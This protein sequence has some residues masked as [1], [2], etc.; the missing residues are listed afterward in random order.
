VLP[1]PFLEHPD[2]YRGQTDVAIEL[3]TA[4][5]TSAQQRQ[6]L[7]RWVEFLSSPRPIHRLELASRVPQ[8][9]VDAVGEQRSLHELFIKFG[10]FSDLAPLGTLTRL[11]VL[12]FGGAG[13]VSDVSPLV[14]LPALRELRLDNPHPEIDIAPLSELVRLRRLS[15]GNGYP[16]ISRSL[17]LPGV[18]WLAPLIDLEQLALPG[19]RLIDPDLTPLLGLP[20]LRELRLPLRRAY[21]KQVTA[22]A[23]E[24]E[25]FSPMLSDYE[26]LDRGGS[27]SD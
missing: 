20:R 15:F 19:V 5:Q 16:G 26:W 7:R 2:D 3:T 12:E 13:K 6:A 11:R 14:A 27:S 8:Q 22:L 21:R 9:I 10:P 25:L 18:G 23:A 24:H 4:E 1:L 17:T